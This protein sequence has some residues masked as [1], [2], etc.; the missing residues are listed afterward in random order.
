ML[1]PHWFAGLQICLL[2]TPKGTHD[3]SCSDCASLWATVAQMQLSRLVVLM[4][5]GKQTTHLA[6]QQI[7]C[8]PSPLPGALSQ[9]ALWQ[10]PVMEGVL[11]NIEALTMQFWE[12]FESR[13]QQ[14]SQP[15]CH[16]TC[17][18]AQPASSQGCAMMDPTLFQI[19][20]VIL[21]GGGLLRGGGS[22]GILC[23]PTT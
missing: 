2:L 22:T 11:Y 19:A 12:S 17:R 4:L 8:R 6:C 23:C 15:M 10:L 3:R 20:A 5:Q 1:Q 16:Q 14:H 21:T 7:I 18:Q 13:S 9:C